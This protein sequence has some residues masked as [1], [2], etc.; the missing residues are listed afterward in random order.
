M[1]ELVELLLQADFLHLQQGAILDF[2]QREA[3]LLSKVI[4]Q[5][6]LRVGQALRRASA[7]LCPHPTT[8][9]RILALPS[10]L[11]WDLYILI[12]MAL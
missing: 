11:Q 12:P 8:C 5:W 1:L 4:D 9:V 7:L 10:L 6:V 2:I 3:V